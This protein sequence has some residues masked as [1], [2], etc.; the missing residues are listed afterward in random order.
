MPFLN[1]IAIS[2][3]TLGLAAAV[4]IAMLPL[5]ILEKWE[6]FPGSQEVS[7]W[8]LF[9]ISLIF[10]LVVFALKSGKFPWRLSRTAGVMLLIVGVLL[11]VEILLTQTCLVQACR[12][13][14]ERPP[15][16]AAMIS[17]WLL[18]VACTLLGVFG[19]Y[20]AKAM[21]RRAEEERAEELERQAEATRAQERSRERLTFVRI[22]RR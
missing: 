6:W 10:G 1:L 19:V 13:D 17:L 5:G 21:Q 18:F 7:L 8:L 20:A 15:D 22:V 9:L 2:F 12:A 14:A 16:V 4:T 11:G 3:L